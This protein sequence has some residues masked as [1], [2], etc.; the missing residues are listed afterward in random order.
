MT[1][2]LTD[3]K[4]RHTPEA[5]IYRDLVHPLLV[6][7]G[8]LP[9]GRLEHAEGSSQDTRLG[10]DWTIMRPNGEGYSIGVRIQRPPDYGT[11]SIRYRTGAG[12]L[13]E[14]TKRYRSIMAGGTFPTY[15]VQ[16][17]VDRERAE[18]LNAYVIRTEALYRHCIHVTDD[19]HFTTCGCVGAKIM[20][21]GGAS[22]LPVAITAVGQ[23]RI[24]SAS[25]LIACGVPVA[26]AR[27][28]DVGMGLWR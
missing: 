24:G 12:N 1:M 5:A 8:V 18:V 27:P 11:F 25:T 6:R 10:I 21:P 15:T 3:G 13:S 17:Y 28:R 22:F 9:D 2:T 7:A 4:Y 14:L 20:A 26:M 16:A 23:N 19:D